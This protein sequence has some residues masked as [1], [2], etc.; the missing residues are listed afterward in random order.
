MTG[1]SAVTDTFL[2]V[3]SFLLTTPSGSARRSPVLTSAAVS[4]DASRPHTPATSAV[5]AQPAASSLSPLTARN[6]QYHASSATAPRASLATARAKASSQN[7]R[8]LA[9]LQSTLNAP[10]LGSGEVA[11]SL[12]G[13]IDAFERRHLGP[14]TA[15][16]QDMLEKIGYSDM[17]AFIHDAVPK[18]IRLDQSTVNKSALQ[19][20]SESELLRRGT[21]IAS[22]NTKHKSLI[23]MGYHNILAPRQPP[24]RPQKPSQRSLRAVWSP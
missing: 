23:G 11:Q 9:T 22:G 21:E 18:S 7:A 2:H 19:P 13:P 15:H 24:Q 1:M 12:F 6:R 14:R 16:I 5:L 20:L 3:H 10:Q 17:D 8:S 4:T